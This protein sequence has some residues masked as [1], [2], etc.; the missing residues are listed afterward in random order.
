MTTTL[1]PATLPC[2]DGWRW[3]PHG[4]DEAMLYARGARGN[5]WGAVVTHVIDAWCFSFCVAMIPLPQFRLGPGGHPTPAA[6]ARAALLALADAGHPEAAALRAAAGEAPRGP[7]R[8]QIA[9][10]LFRLGTAGPDEPIALTY[11][12]DRDP[13]RGQPTDGWA[14][15]IGRTTHHGPAALDALVRL[16]GGDDG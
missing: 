16:L 4:P 14:V 15:V 6:A 12:P 7:T 5:Q 13:A 3:E 1:D 11:D 2:P 9:A 8:Q 10:M